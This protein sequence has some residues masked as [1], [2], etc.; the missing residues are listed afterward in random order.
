MPRYLFHIVDG[1]SRPNSVRDSEGTV[2]RD[3]TEARKE[4]VGLAQD[5]AKHRL[6][7][8]NK[9][10]I[11]VTDEHGTTVL[12]VPLSEVLTLRVR[13]WTTLRGLVASLVYRSPR[14]LAWSLA[15]GVIMAQ[16]IALAVLLREQ[17]GTYQTASAPSQG[18]LVAI[19]FAGAA[20]VDDITRFMETHQSSIVDGPR[21]GGF[22]R[23]RLSHTTLPRDEFARLVARMSDAKI[24]D[25]VA[26]VE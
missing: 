8:A 23:V 15:A 26:A 18:A 3:A 9:W 14:S 6:D 12:I 19:R 22:Y 1:E 21:A 24:V 13:A 2:L 11:V 16:A 4:A 17:P 10:K 25:F 20:T 7:G 5:I